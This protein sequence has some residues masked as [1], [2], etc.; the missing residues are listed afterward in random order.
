MKIICEK[1]KSV[2][3]W[4]SVNGVG[5]I[6]YSLSCELVAMHEKQ[7]KETKNKDIGIGRLTRLEIKT[8]I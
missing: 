3:D 7:A 8:E 1:E 2:F 6:S 4:V 5:I